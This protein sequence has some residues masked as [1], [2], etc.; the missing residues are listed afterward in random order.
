MATEPR[1]ERYVDPTSILLGELPT[2]R[3]GM[4]DFHYYYQA[5]NKPLLYFLEKCKQEGRNY[6]SIQDFK[7]VIGLCT[8][9]GVDEPS[10]AI[11]NTLSATE[12]NKE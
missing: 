11:I 8:F 9:P 10:N 4:K 12:R 1:D 7:E 6:L 2:S 5:Y 3:P